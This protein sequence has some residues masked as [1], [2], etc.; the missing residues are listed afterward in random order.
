MQFKFFNKKR[1]KDRRR[2]PDEA[3][4]TDYSNERAPKSI[5]SE[6]LLSFDLKFDGTALSE[7]T[8]GFQPGYY[9]LNLKKVR[10]GARMVLAMVNP[11]IP[12]IGYLKELQTGEEALPALEAF[13]RSHD[14]ARFNGFHKV[15]PA[16]GEQFSLDVR[17]GSEEKIS[18]SAEGGAEVLPEGWDPIPYLQYFAEVFRA[19]GELGDER[20]SGEQKP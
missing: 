17:Y 5:L 20:R 6:E 14:L 1:R 3:G 11:A 16:P 2:F 8:D 12:T 18:A 9:H 19:A 10:G 15:G 7:E 4:V 13:V